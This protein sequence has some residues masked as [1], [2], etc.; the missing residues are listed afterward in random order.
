MPPDDDDDGDIML[1]KDWKEKDRKC[2]IIGYTSPCK[3][4]HTYA[5]AFR[6]LP[7][8]HQSR[9]TL[10]KTRSSRTAT[11]SFSQSIIL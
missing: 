5:F 10:E 6:F 1:G 3:Y 8:N 9:L 7:T 11:Y 2:R 4:A